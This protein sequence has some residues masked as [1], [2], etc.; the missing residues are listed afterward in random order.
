MSIQ[1]VHH[2]CKPIDGGLQLIDQLFYLS[3]EV[4]FS[5]LRRDGNMPLPGQRFIDHERLPALQ[6][7]AEVRGRAKITS[8]FPAG[9]LGRRLRCSLL[10]DPRVG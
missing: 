10:T 4:A 9:S 8:H 5:S 6:Y 3:G 1:I 7:H 2:Q